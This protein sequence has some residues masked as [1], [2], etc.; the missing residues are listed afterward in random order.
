MALIFSSIF[1]AIFSSFQ[2]SEKIY[3]FHCDEK[4]K[5]HKALFT[6][7][8]GNSYPVCCHGCVA[9]LQVIERNGMTMQYLQAKSSLGM[10]KLTQ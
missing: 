2:A 8:N 1:G 3:C 10:P 9:V 5:K 7:F 4:M 6:A